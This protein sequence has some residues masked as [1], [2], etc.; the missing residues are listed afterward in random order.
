M[1][2][3]DDS[4]RVSISGIKSTF[5]LNP[6]AGKAATRA[7]RRERVLA[8][9]ARHQLDAHLVETATPRHA[10]ALA[11]DAIAAGARLV[12]SIGGDGTMNEVATALVGTRVFYGLVPSGSGNGLG[13]DLGIP[14]GFDQALA[15][16]LDARVRCIDTGSINGLPFFNVAGLGFDA[17]ISRR[18]NQC[19]RR[20][21]A[22]YFRI[23]CGALFTYRK[24]M[25]GITPLSGVEEKVVSFVT[26]VA[27]STQYGNNARIAPHALLDDGL[28][29]LAVIKTGNPFL[30]VPLGLRLFAGS[31][32]RA[33]SVRSIQSSTFTIRRTAAGPIH[34]DGEVHAC[35]ATLQ[36]QVVPRSLLVL[37]PHSAR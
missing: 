28:L 19:E 12:V 4:G 21:L 31:I 16:L 22:S 18:F 35:S 13:R 29:D 37:V 34:T 8:F 14:L 2:S 7:R 26:T 9:I 25:L 10:T 24:E 32:D 5:I 20:G 1:N 6:T 17:E 11:Q 36:V 23:G 3:R 15:A 30:A 27:N 33:P